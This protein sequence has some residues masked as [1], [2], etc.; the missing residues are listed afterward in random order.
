MSEDEAPKVQVA[1][2]I[3]SCLK[4]GNC[5]PFLELRSL[6]SSLAKDLEL[7]L[8]SI[9]IGLQNHNLAS[10]ITLSDLLN[11]QNQI[12]TTISKQLSSIKSELFE[13]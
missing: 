2:I 8:N 11:S 7:S 3:M 5:D 4:N 13:E 1:S 6:E 9:Y 10:L 12:L